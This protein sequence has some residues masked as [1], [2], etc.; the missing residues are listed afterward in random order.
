V[1]QV[2]AIRE[3]H[4]GA[5]DDRTSVRLWLRLLSCTTVMEKRIKRRL[6]DRYD[7]TLP[8]FDVMAALER[9]PEGMTMGALSRALLVSNGNVTGVVQA[10]LRDGHVGLAASPT[11]GR[12][13]IVRLTPAGQE[14]FTGLAEAHHDW[15]DDMLAG[16]TRRERDG[17]YDLLGALK[18][19][20]AEDAGEEQP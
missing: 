1:S 8:R 5:L 2:H 10:L 9:H 17:L 19:S 18:Q 12:A 16:M 3:K 6:A 15:V 7:A 4:D 20:I 13:S 14:Y 11:D